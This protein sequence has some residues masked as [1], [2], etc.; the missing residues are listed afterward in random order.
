MCETLTKKRTPHIPYCDNHPTRII[1][2]TTQTVEIIQQ[3]RETRE[4]QRRGDNDLMQMKRETKQNQWT[5]R[6]NE[7]INLPRLSTRS[8]SP[9]GDRK[10]EP[11]RKCRKIRSPT[12]HEEKNNERI[13]TMRRGRQ[14]TIHHTMPHTNQ[15]FY[16]SLTFDTDCN[17]ASHSQFIPPFSTHLGATKEGKWK[18]SYAQMH[19]KKHLCK[20]FH[21]ST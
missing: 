15:P 7:E 16:L 11:K 19:W 10:K 18:S 4:K 20:Q 14:P 6:G 5:R 13:K 1:R 17:A 3:P 8:D 12:N 9:W 21:A 2:K